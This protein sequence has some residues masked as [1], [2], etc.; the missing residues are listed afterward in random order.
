MIYLPSVQNLSIFFEQLA[1][2]CLKETQ[3]GLY[4]ERRAQFLT[5]NQPKTARRANDPELHGC[6][7]SPLMFSTTSEVEEL[8][9]GRAGYIRGA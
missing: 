3:T 7:R 9:G 8:R 5:Q 4:H 2:N 6:A 1:Q